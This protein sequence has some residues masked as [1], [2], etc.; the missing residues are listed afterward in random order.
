[1]LNGTAVEAAVGTEVEEM[2]WMVALLARSDELDVT[3][4]ADCE[5]IVDSVCESVVTVELDAVCESEVTVGL[6][7]LD[8][9]DDDSVEV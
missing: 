2:F 5:K 6:D 3:S 1:M 7:S 4:L 8:K 9:V